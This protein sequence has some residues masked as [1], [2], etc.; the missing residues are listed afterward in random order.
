MQI[1]EKLQLIFFLDS[2]VPHKEIEDLK[3]RMSSSTINKNF[4]QKCLNFN[5][6][7]PEIK[8]VFENRCDDKEIIIFLTEFYKENNMASLV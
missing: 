3:Q 1:A 2:R 7:K 4:L 8:N 6:I 5:D